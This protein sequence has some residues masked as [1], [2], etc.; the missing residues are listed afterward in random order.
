MINQTSTKYQNL[1]NNNN[2]ENKM[3]LMNQASTK[4]H[5]LVNTNKKENKVGLM[6]QAPTRRLIITV[7]LMNQAPTKYL[8]KIFFQVAGSVRYF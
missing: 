2:K 7:D 8:R 3:D 4:N 6:N 5:N 1:V